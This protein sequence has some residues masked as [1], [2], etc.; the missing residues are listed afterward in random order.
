MSIEVPELHPALSLA[1]RKFSLA[2]SGQLNFPPP[3]ARTVAAAAFLSAQEASIR[4]AQPRAA[5]R[6]KTVQAKVIPSPE[7]NDFFLL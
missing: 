5:S 4:R 1:G 2:V 3:H 6:D 7:Q